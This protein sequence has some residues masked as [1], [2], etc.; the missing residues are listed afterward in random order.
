MTTTSIRPTPGQQTATH[1]GPGPRLAVGAVLACLGMWLLVGG[2][3]GL[4]MHDPDAD[5][6][7]MTGDRPFSTDAHAIVSA[8]EIGGTGPDVFY[9]RAMVGPIRIT[10]EAGTPGDELFLGI[11]PADQVERY[12]DDVEHSELVDLNVWPF[13][14]DYTERQGTSL[15]ADPDDQDFWIESTSGSGPLTL[16]TELPAEDWRAVVM[17]ADGAASVEADLAVGATLPVFGWTLAVC[18]ALG[19]LM[20]AVGLIL[21]VSGLRAHPAP[22]R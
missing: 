20:A 7:H 22:R 21:L 14:V 8:P 1:R 18:F 2:L 13:A 17:N 3:V 12:L 10:G 6:F 4:M 11:G 15:P 16:E 19:G 5:G 9:G